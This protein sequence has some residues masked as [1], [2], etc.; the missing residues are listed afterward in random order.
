[1][2]VEVH[3]EVAG[4]WGSRTRVRRVTSGSSCG[5]VLVNEASEDRSASNPGMDRLEDGRLRAWWTQ[6]EGSMR[7]LPVVVRGVLGLSFALN[8]GQLWCGVNDLGLARYGGFRR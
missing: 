4:L 3:D 6:L 5:F 2:V 1:V 7:S 8:A